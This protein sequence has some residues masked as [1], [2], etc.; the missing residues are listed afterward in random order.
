MM[1][2]RQGHGTDSPTPRPWQD[3]LRC[4]AER[5]ALWWVAHVVEAIFVFA[6]LIAVL[7]AI[8]GALPDADLSGLFPEKSCCRGAE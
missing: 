5:A 1:T 6:M 7:A 4:G 8:F 2:S 3:K